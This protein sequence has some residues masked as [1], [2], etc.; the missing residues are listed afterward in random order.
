MSVSNAR[1]TFMVG[2]KDVDPTVDNVPYCPRTAIPHKRFLRR[3]SV[4]VRHALFDSGSVLCSTVRRFLQALLIFSVGVC[5]T[6]CQRPIEQRQLANGHSL[7][8]LIPPDGFLALLVFD[9][10]E[11]TSCFGTMSEWSAA[12]LNT[13][14]AVRLVASRE[15][16]PIESRL[17][18]THRIVLDG[19]LV[20]DTFERAPATSLEYWYRNGK[21][22]AVDTMKARKIKSRVLDSLRAATRQH[23]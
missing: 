9:P 1:R 10:K 22:T 5:L 15:P 7:R 23:E 8:T 20:T 19:V 18:I 6:G 2:L 4:S 3:S 12:R 13:A 21:L 11:C 16:T 14:Q 17:F